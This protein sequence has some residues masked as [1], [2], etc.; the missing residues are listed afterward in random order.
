M[1]STPSRPSSPPFPPV[2]TRTT[3][4]TAF[5]LFNTNDNA[6]RTTLSSLTISS[7]SRNWIVRRCLL[8]SFQVLMR[9]VFSAIAVY[10]PTSND[11]LYTLLSTLLTTLPLLQSTSILYYLLLSSDPPA[12]ARYAQA[13]LI[14]SAYRQSIAAFAALDHNDYKRAIA[15]LAPLPQPEFVDKIITLLS[16][17]PPVEQRA[18]LVL[19]YWRM[20][21]VTLDGEVQLGLILDALCDKTRRYGVQ[22]AWKLMRKRE[23][24]QEKTRLVERILSRCLGGAKSF[25]LS[26]Y[27]TDPCVSD[28]ATSKPVPHHLLTLLAQPFTPEEDEIT[29]SFI[30]T[31]T[32]LPNIFLSLA[33]DWRISK[34]V[35]EGRPVDALRFGREIEGRELGVGTE[36]RSKLLVSVRETLT[37]VQHGQVDLDAEAD[38]PAAPT[39]STSALK[40]SNIA[41]PA[42]QPAPLLA[43]VPLPT[44]L[45]SVAR[46]APSAPEPTAIDLPLSASPFLRRDKPQVGTLDGSSLGGAQKSVLRA[47]REG[48]A[49]V[50]KGKARASPFA[51]V[52]LPTLTAGSERFGSPG[53]PASVYARSEQSTLFGVSNE[54]RKPTLAGFGSMRLPGTPNR[55]A[56]M[57]DPLRPREQEQEGS[58]SEDEEAGNN[59]FAHQAIRDPAIAATLAAATASTQ[60]RTLA[61]QTPNKRRNF[62]SQQLLESTAE[63]KRAVSVEAEDR[64]SSS[65]R[66]SN[67]AVRSST[68]TSR[69]PGGFPGHSEEDDDEEEIVPAPR[70]KTRATKK[71]APKATP[72]KKGRA[73]AISTGQKEST[74][75]AKRATSVQLETPRMGVRRSTRLGT[76]AP[77]VDEEMVAKPKKS[78]R[79]RNVVEEE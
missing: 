15:L 36:E 28:N 67:G 55:D 40:S 78:T 75:R 58:S 50:D 54:I 35:A 68:R 10:P 23:D 74:P 73:S 45:L 72:A 27:T 9:L 70:A 60:K 69:P 62:S 2:S 61:A 33:A 52:R 57:V 20:A 16:T 76:P 43:P 6:D 53:R 24:A 44:S 46:P 77:D 26:R 49:P 63:K 25:L 21:G 22:E 79:A 71:A 5:P 51:S 13:K 39:A 11:A 14:P 66:M 7:P 3:P 17:L 64:P 38:L 41:T 56:T 31:S 65:V 4:A 59:T 37:E 34:F 42:W 19:S 29:S 48:T 30:L 12:A 32:S 1:F 8:A 18:D 47:V